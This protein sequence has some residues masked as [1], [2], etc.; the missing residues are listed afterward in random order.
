MSSFWGTSEFDELITNATSE[1]RPSGD[2]DLAK[3]IDIADYIKSK[4]VSPKD[5]TKALRRRLTHT[6]PNVVLL[7]LH[8][9]EF[10]V[11]NAGKLFVNEVATV[12]FINVIKN[13]SND[14]ASDTA[15]RAKAKEL[16]QVW[17]LAARNDAKLSNFTTTYQ[18]MKSSGIKIFL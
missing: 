4:K 10:C 15:T 2:I 3:T 18:E 11:Q 6:N 16:I 1:L 7:A 8:L 9:C 14:K 12:D 17:G 13:I 5:A